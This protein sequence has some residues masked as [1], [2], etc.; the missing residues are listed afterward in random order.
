[1]KTPSSSP[2]SNKIAKFVAIANQIKDGTYKRKIKID[3]RNYFEEIDTDVWEP[4]EETRIQVR[5]YDRS[6]AFIEKAV[7]HCVNTGDHSNLD[8]LVLVYFKKTDEY[9]IIGGN[10]T[11]EIMIRLGIYESDAYVVDFEEDLQGRMSV[12]VDFGNEL[13]HDAKMKQP[14]SVDDVKNIVMTH[15]DE[16]IDAGLKDPRPSKEFKDDLL[17]RYTFITAKQ[18]GAWCGWEQ[19]T[20][21]RRPAKSYSPEKI[22]QQ[23]QVYKDMLAY[24]HHE[25]LRPRELRSWDQITISTFMNKYIREDI[26]LFL[27]IFYPENAAQTVA[28]KSGEM[29]KKIRKLYD[30]YEEKVGIKIDTVFLKG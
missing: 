13:N 18:L 16:N 7:N 6:L 5:E 27:L 14:T 23:W 15:I 25:I 2:T 19:K 28:L 22:E 30:D 1:M 12:A 21:G 26:K 11:S 8:I 24:E 9:K 20:G 10:H 3:L 17:S 4:L 29:Q